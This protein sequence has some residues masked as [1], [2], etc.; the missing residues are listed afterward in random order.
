VCPEAPWKAAPLL[1]REQGQELAHEYLRALR[2]G[3]P[4]GRLRISDK[5]PF[6][7]FQLGFA[8]LLFPQARVIHC[9]RNARDN[10]LSIYLEN[11]NPDQHYATDFGD[12]AHLRR[13]Y[14]CLMEHWRG[15]LPLRILEV[16]YEALVADT[17]A[18]ARRIVDFLGAPWDR[19]C[20]EFH[21]SERAVQTPSR[22]QVRER[23]YTRSVQRWRLYAPYLPE[24]EAAFPDP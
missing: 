8:A 6:N 22:W 18:Q 17:E 9:R 7:F 20:L 23:I 10:A 1:T 15:A 24:L 14:E 12:I 2:E 5:L 3:A 4:K 13:G 19:R 21:Q 16:D 11:F